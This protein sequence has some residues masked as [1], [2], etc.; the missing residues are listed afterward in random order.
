MRVIFES[1]EI[2]SRVVNEVMMIVFFRNFESSD[3]SSYM[4]SE[5]AG[6][7]FSKVKPVLVFREFFS[8]SL[9]S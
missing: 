1:L 7:F 5:G 3:T 6:S 9:K 8:I 2:C 4:I